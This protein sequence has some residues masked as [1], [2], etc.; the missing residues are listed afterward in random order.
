MR[1]SWRA[2]AS[3]GERPPSVVT[4]RAHGT[5]YAPPRSWRPLALQVSGQLLHGVGWVVRLTWTI[6]WALLRLVVIAVLVLVEPFVRLILLGFGYAAFLLSVIGG[7]L[8][9]LPRLPKWGILG[10]AVG[11]VVLYLLFLLVMSLFMRLPRD[12]D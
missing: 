10:I 3:P 9:D 6:G 2:R 8:L 5:Y 4:L 1:T 7:F 11:C 12:R